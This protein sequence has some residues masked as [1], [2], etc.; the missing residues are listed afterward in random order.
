MKGCPEITSLVH[1][2][3]DLSLTPC[4][5][6][7]RP[8]TATFSGSQLPSSVGSGRQGAREPTGFGQLTQGGGKG[9]G[10]VVLLRGLVVRE[11]PC[12]PNLG[13]HG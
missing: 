4:R 6:M 8:S 3:D 13:K 7:F 11:V 1:L 9:E 5:T 2:R 12:C 10:D